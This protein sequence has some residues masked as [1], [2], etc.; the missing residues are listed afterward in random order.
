MVVSMDTFLHWS[1]FR[2][3]ISTPKNGRSFC[4]IS[5]ASASPQSS[6][7]WSVEE[8]CKFTMVS[9]WWLVVANQA[10]SQVT[11]FPGGAHP[12]YWNPRRPEGFYPI[13]IFQRAADG[14]PYSLPSLLQLKTLGMD[15]W[16]FFCIHASHIIHQYIR[17][18]LYVYIVCTTSWIRMLCVHISA[19]YIQAFT[20]YKHH[21]LL[22]P[23]DHDPH[24]H[25]LTPATYMIW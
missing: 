6:E 15:R 13:L 21:I 22:Q 5:W 9:D 23:H 14:Q 16:R 18:M 10:Y 25:W 12:L 2:A 1:R 20:T 4:R 8:W 24:D 3:Q 11:F 19:L 17:V 7:E